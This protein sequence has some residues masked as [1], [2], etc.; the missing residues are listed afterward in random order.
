M[1]LQSANLF[2]RGI[3]LISKFLLI[4]FVAKELTPG[5]LGEYGLLV[6]TVSYYLYLVGLDYYT[7][8][9]REV[10]RTDKSQYGRLLKSQGFLIGILYVF[11][12]PST[13]LIFYFKLLPWEM[14]VWFLILLIF[15][16]VNQEVMRLLI[17]LSKPFVATLTLFFR[18]GL[19]AVI[20]VALTFYSFITLSLEMILVA[21]VVG[22]VMAFCFGLFVLVQ[23]KINFS[24]ANVDRP[25]IWKGIK[26]SLPFLIGTLAIRGIWTVDR[27][28]VE[29]QNTTEMLGAYTL[30]VGL[31]AAMASFM[32]AGVYSFIYPRMISSYKS[33]KYLE[34]RGYVIQMT[35]QTIIV[36]LLFALGGY[37]LIDY[38]LTW[39]D[40]N[41]YYEYK[42]MFFLLLGANFLYCLSMIPHYML[43]SQGNDKTIIFSSIIALL[44]FLSFA[45]FGNMGNSAYL[46]PTGLC[47]AFFVLLLLKL[48]VGLKYYF[49]W[50]RKKKGGV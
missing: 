25:W 13:L 49:E 39:L 14:L 27:Y 24:D 4:I 37:V 8:S 45:V 10:I 3:N 17:A 46:I 47:L 20:L 28:I 41:I 30:F 1:L 12:L 23:Q 6:A 32:D 18:S 44:V 19:W 42:A 22:E 5:E 40:K 26:I 7:Y 11:V 9:T 33:K 38:L 15:E 16:H 36:S 29:A 43:Y 21:W 48:V 35:V 2:L 34:Y 31:A 50:L